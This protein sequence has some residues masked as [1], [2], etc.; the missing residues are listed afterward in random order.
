METIAIISQLS[1]YVFAFLAV[2]LCVILFRHYHQ[3]AWLLV[4]VAFV[5]PFWVLLMR[6][7]HGRPL[8]YY[9]TMTT[10]PDG[11]LKTGYRVEFPVFYIVAIIEL[12]L[13]VKKTRHETVA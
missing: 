7:I 6:I 12:Y 5:Q 8:L 10:A 13:L 11:S 2:A 9:I 1:Y 3:F 4:S